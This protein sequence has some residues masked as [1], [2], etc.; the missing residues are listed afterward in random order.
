VHVDNV[1]KVR[2]HFSSS[3]QEKTKRFSIGKCQ[4]M[5]LAYDSRPLVLIL[6]FIITFSTA[7]TYNPISRPQPGEIL[8][9]G[10]TYNI[11]WTPNKGSIVGLEIWN[12]FPITLSFNQSNCVLDDNNTLCSQLDPGFPNSGSYSWK[13]P[14]T[15]PS[16]DEYYLDIYVPNPGLGGPFYY[17]TGNFSIRKASPVVVSAVPSTTIA[18]IASTT[19]SIPPA[20][21]ASNHSSEHPISLFLTIVPTNDRQAASTSSPKDGGGLST[22]AVGAIVGAVLGVALAISLAIIFTLCYRRIKSTSTRPKSEI[23]PSGR[24]YHAESIDEKDEEWQVTQKEEPFENS[25]PVGRRIRYPDEDEVV[26][27]RVRN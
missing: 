26:G 12:S 7:Q 25:Q 22:G 5:M 3:L 16:S 23:V 2:H 17:M 13:I 9:A 4:V 19:G 14:D 1:I 21:A 10:S 6:T 15:A 8:T 18:S 11:V 27:G 20:S 24:T